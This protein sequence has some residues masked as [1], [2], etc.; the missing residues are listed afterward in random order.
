MSYVPVKSPSQ[1]HSIDAIMAA[2]INNNNRISCAARQLGITSVTLKKYMKE[3]PAIQDMVDERA[4]ILCD[5][6]WTAIS[7]NI[8][9]ETPDPALIKFALE[10]LDPKFQKVSVNNKNV[11]ITGNPNAPVSFSGAIN[12]DG[13]SL[14]E[15]KILLKAAKK[16]LGI[17]EDANHIIDASPIDFSG[18]IYQYTVDDA[19]MPDEQEEELDDDNSNK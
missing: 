9:S 16:E 15:K 10:R 18:G 6:A 7:A 8:T 1:R 2:L 17:N 11:H 14:E 5:Q 3:Q 4:Q 19:C 13:L 12:V